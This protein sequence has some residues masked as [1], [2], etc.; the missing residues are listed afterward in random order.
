MLKQYRFK[1]LLRANGFSINSYFGEFDVVA[2]NSGHPHNFATVTAADGR[3]VF[4]CKNMPHHD[5]EKRAA[6]MACSY[7]IPV[8][9]NAE[10]GVVFGKRGESERVMKNVRSLD[11]WDILPEADRPYR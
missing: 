8:R 10:R 9:L 4:S 6:A 11:V 2:N 7:G 1:R 5:Y 3:L